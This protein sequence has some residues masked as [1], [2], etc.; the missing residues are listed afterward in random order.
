MAHDLSEVLRK[1]MALPNG[2]R[3][4]LAGALLE[5]LDARISTMDEAQWAAEIAARLADMNCRRGTLL[6][7]PR[8]P[9]QI[10]EE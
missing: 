3:A 1:A 5:S 6:A 7:W 9:G 2:A 4:A 10:R 8:Q